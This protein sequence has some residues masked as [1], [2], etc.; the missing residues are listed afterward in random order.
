MEDN[1]EEDRFWS[2]VF[3]IQNMTFACKS[4]MIVNLG[5][6]DSLIRHCGM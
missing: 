3:C 4:F 6:L 1:L 2:V 5:H